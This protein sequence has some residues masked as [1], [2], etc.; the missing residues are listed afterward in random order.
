MKYEIY[1]LDTL[2][3]YIWYKLSSWDNKWLIHVREKWFFKFPS[4]ELACWTIDILHVKFDFYH[5]VK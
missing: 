5:V 4:H 2:S 1:L 3:I